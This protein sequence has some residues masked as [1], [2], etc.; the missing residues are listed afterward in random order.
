MKLLYGLTLA[1]GIDGLNAHLFKGHR[2]AVVG[3]IA[4]EIDSP[5][6]PLAQDKLDVVPVGQLGPGFQNL[7]TG[8]HC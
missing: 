1:F 4:S 7:L 6:A 2:L 5:H 8:V 3:Q